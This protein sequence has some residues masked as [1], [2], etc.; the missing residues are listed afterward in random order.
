MNYVTTSGR[1]ASFFGSG[2]PCGGRVRPAQH[3]KTEDVNMNEDRNSEIIRR[4]YA[5]ILNR[6]NWNRWKY[7]FHRITPVKRL[8][9]IRG[10]EGFARSIGVIMKALPDVQW[11]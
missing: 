6:K 8:R 1:N 4:F 5:E 11:K 7:L 2:F 9:H 3:Q 10:S